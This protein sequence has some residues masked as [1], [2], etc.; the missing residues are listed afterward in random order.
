LFPSPYQRLS[1][2]LLYGFI[3]EL[4]QEEVVRYPDLTETFSFQKFSDLPAGVRD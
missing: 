2:F 3:E 1:F 4:G